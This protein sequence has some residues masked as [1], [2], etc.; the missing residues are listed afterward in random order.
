VFS[1]KTCLGPPPKH[2]CHLSGTSQNPAQ[3]NTVAQQP[4]RTKHGI[5]RCT[6]EQKSCISHV[7]VAALQS[8]D[9]AHLLTK[10]RCRLVNNK[11]TH[12]CLGTRNEQHQGKILTELEPKEALCFLT[13]SALSMAHVTTAGSIIKQRDMNKHIMLTK[14][15]PQGMDAGCMCCLC[16]LSR[17]LQNRPPLWPTGPNGTANHSKTATQ[18]QE[19]KRL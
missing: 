1:E 3:T 18:N 13:G 7:L 14:P 8:L 2:R 5:Y 16:C 4:A 12:H 6:G 19:V 17:W 10:R 15:T 11:Q 9:G